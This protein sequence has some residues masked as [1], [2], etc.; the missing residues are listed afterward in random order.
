MKKKILNLALKM[1]VVALLDSSLAYSYE[2]YQPKIQNQGQYMTIPQ[3]ALAKN[4][5]P[6]YGHVLSAINQSSQLAPVAQDK[7]LK[8]SIVFQLNHEEEL[9]KKLLSITDPNSPDYQHFLSQSEFVNRY[10]PTLEQMK[11]ASEFFTKNGMNVESI[12]DNRLIVRVSAPV[13]AIEKVFHTKLFYYSD[14]AGKKYYAPGYE[15]QVDNSLKIVSVQG[16]ENRIKA[17]PNFIKLNKDS[18]LAKAGPTSGLT[19]ANIKTAY[20][21][22]STLNGSGQTLALFELDGYTASDIT[23]YQKAFNLP[24]VTLQNVLVD[25][26]TGRPSN[27][28]GPSEVTL[29]IELMNALVPSASKILVYEGPNTGTGL[30]DTY[31]RIATDNLAKS[32]ST[33]WGLDESDSGSLIQSESTIFKQM[34]AQ[35][36][37]LYA[38]AGDAGAY[39]DGK[40]LSVDDPASQPYVV[41]VG[42]TRLTTNS[43]GSYKSESTWSSG[44]GTS[45][46]GGGGGI[47][48]VWSIP[49]WQQGVVSSASLGSQTMRNV[50]DVSLD[51]D[52]A[53]GYAILYKGKWNVYGGT[54]CAAPLWAAFHAL[55]NQGRGNNG[56]SSLGFPN[57]TLYALGQSASY[58][59]TF[60]DIADKSTNLHYPAVTGYDLATGWGTFVGDALI[61]ALVGGSTPPPPVCTSAN[62]T[63]SIT[64]S[65]QQ[66]TA[67]GVLTY[68]MT[69][70]NNDSSACSASSFNLAA[71]MPTGFTGV[72]S[73]SSLSIAPA[74]SQNASIKVTSQSNVAAGNYVFSVKATNAG[75]STYQSSQSATYSVASTQNQPTLTITPQN[76]V[77]TYNSNQTQTFSFALNQGNTPLSGNLIYVN[78]IG[79]YSAWNTI[80][81]TQANG[82]AQ[83]QLYMNSSVSVGHY[84]IVATAMNGDTSIPGETYFTVQ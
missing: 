80:L 83:Y 74:T 18:V 63:V 8:L 67:G 78:F 15:L 29:D 72:L 14:K 66:S 19:P 27:T 39:D 53:T 38:A 62:P 51:A 24:A 60:H 49:Q 68:N 31:N 54:S 76:G 56:S 65:S 69:V 9:D 44:S 73:Q 55:V 4:M 12:S 61:T 52:P 2:G 7:F 47:S 75:A 45:G 35:G 34:V 70:T 84:T 46:N 21:L 79:P 32:I 37:V 33:S 1:S 5:R 71:T 23:A 57:P 20:S 16:L 13:A 64:P 41:G 40:T 30:V 28:D 42:G 48:S 50:P 82:V 77:F 6:L 25:G 43:N 3:T 11:K 22:S 81:W 36:Q 26:V 58:A 59:S 17:H 10:A